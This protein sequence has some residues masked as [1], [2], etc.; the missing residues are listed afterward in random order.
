MGKVEMKFFKIWDKM[1]EKGI[2]NWDGKRKE[3]LKGKLM[4]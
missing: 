2:L 1:L 4:D 3:K